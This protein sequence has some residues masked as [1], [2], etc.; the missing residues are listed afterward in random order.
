MSIGHEERHIAAGVIQ[1]RQAHVL[2]RVPIFMSTLCRVRQGEKHI[3]DGEREMRAGPQHMVLMPAG[4]ELG[5]ANHPG[6]SGYYI[7]DTVSFSSDFLRAFRIRLGVQNQVQQGSALC[8]PLDSHSANAWTNLLACL[9]TNAPQ[10]MRNHY[11]EGVL[12]A[13]SLAGQAGPL[14]TDRHDPLA[15]RVEQLLMHDPA[16]NWSVASVAE[17][18]HMGASTL[19]RRLAEEGSSFSHILEQAR[20]GFALQCLQGTARPIGEI[21][22]ACGYASASRFSARF[23]QHYGLSPRA[24]RAAM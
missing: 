5:M 10:A 15:A 6:S 20:L 12:L 18:L 24:L 19:R 3:Q 17:R 13:L 2:R 23:R 8:V 7:A 22:A 11:A 14:L 21:A 16:G 9:A 1:A 4:R